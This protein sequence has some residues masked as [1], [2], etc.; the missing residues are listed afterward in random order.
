MT[1]AHQHL[2]DLVDTAVCG[3]LCAGA[4]AGFAIVLP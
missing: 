1:A 4:V 2:F 3:T